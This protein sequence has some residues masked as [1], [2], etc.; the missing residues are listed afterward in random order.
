[1]FVLEVKPEIILNSRKEET[2]QIT[3]KT[4]EG[5]F[6]VSAPSGKS[7]GKQEVGPYNSKGI[8]RSLF[9]L[10]HF[11]K[12]LIHQNFFI[13]K[14]NDLKQIR[15]LIYRFEKKYGRLGGNVTYALEGVF[16]RAAAA[17]AH[18]DVFEFINN[19][20]NLGMNVKIPMPVGNCIGGGLHSEPV[21]GFRPDFQEFLLIP[22]EKT[23]SRAIT[24][25][26]RAYEY[27]K[28]LL[29]AKKR[30][31]ENAWV[32]GLSNEDVLDILREIKDKFGF[33]IGL[34]VAASTFYSNG[35]YRYKNKEL[36][37]DKR[38]QADYISRLAKKYGIFYI[39]DPIQEED[40]S[41]FTE[42]M[43]SVPKKAKG[44]PKTLVVGD[45]LTVTNPKLLRRAVKAGSINAIIIKPNQIGSIL[46]VKEV[47][48]ICKKNDIIMIFS[49]RSGETMDDLISD[50]AVGFGA[51]FVKFGIYGRERLIKLK[52]I[53]DIELKI[54]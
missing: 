9:L 23:F 45:D 40:F 18:V 44:S 17:D 28:K 11:S 49:H 20:M 54:S 26:L 32:T 22:R 30:N 38:D 31:D 8:S 1:M 12:Q 13:K 47:V 37:R 53:R 41:G 25:N 14:V 2:I 29:K 4:Y 34:D 46:N 42:V 10:K 24:V 51:D 5:K 39:E 36:V 35:Y 43:N 48:E 21:N 7:L 52:R 50:L 3:L 19:D 33:R 6:V 16:L 15:E 27:A